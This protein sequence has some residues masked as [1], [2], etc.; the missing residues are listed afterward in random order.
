M[1]G[2]QPATGPFIGGN[3]VTGEAGS[4]PVLNPANERHMG[5][6]SLV[7][8]AKIDEQVDEDAEEEHDEEPRGRRRHGS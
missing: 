4:R 8:S 1:A 3:W 5:S 7:S 6:L 2:E